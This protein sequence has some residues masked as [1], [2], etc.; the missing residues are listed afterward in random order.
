MQE[1]LLETELPSSQWREPFGA[2]PYAS[3][4]ILQ[5][6]PTA[7]HFQHQDEGRLSPH[8]HHFLNAKTD[9]QLLNCLHV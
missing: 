3:H 8:A 4:G 7:A 9:N 2:H 1:K 6:T 5:P